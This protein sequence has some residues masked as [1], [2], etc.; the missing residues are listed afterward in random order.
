MNAPP[1][2]SADQLLLEGNISPDLAGITKHISIDMRNN[3]Y[4]KAHKIPHFVAIKAAIII[5]NTQQT[6]P[7]CVFFTNIQMCRHYPF[8]S[9]QIASRLP[10]IMNMPGATLEDS[11]EELC[12]SFS[13]PLSAFLPRLHAQ[14]NELTAHAQYSA[15]RILDVMDPADIKFITQI[16]RRQSINY[17]P[18]IKQDEV[19]KVQNLEFAESANLSS[20]LM[21]WNDGREDRAD[22]GHLM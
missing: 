9:K 10:D 14:Q 3:Q 1:K 20:H 19:A 21:M 17:N 13:E 6:G 22:E 16:L 8:L 11:F 5:Y 7:P 12:L 4:L 18:V 15:L 2:R